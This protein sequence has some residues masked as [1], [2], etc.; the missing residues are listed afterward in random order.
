MSVPAE[1]SSTI[2]HKHGNLKNLEKREM[3]DVG[4]KIKSLLLC[5]SSDSDKERLPGRPDLC[6]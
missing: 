5:T 6:S 3:K 1:I 2:F 4:L